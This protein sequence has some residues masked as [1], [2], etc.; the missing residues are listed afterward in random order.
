M[1]QRISLS[2]LDPLLTTP[3][4][5]QYRRL[6]LPSQL[7]PEAIVGL[8]HLAAMAAAIGWA[9]ATTRWWGGLLGAAGVVGNHLCDIFDGTHAR[10]TGQCRHGGELLDHFTDPLSF[11][12]ILAG[13][14]VGMGRLDLALA[15]VIVLMATAVLTNIRA[16]LTGKFTL[17]RL[18]PTEFKALLAVGGGVVWGL[19]V[20]C[21]GVI[22]TRVL[23]GSFRLLLTLAAVQLVV[24]VIKSVREVNRLPT[25]PDASDWRSRDDE[26]RENSTSNRG[27]QQN[28][29]TAEE[30]L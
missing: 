8:G 28:N 29:P 10:A 3:L 24:Q 2:W 5:R 11:S 26:A 4:K 9:F 1:S 23:V 12:Y 15:G 13:I 20:S 27:G 25:A 22:A 30:I 19:Q 17:D 21:G 6:S 7:P 16:K 14:G 18:G